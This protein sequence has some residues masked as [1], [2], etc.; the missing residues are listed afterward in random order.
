M[1]DLSTQVAQAANARRTYVRYQVLR[2]RGKRNIKRFPATHWRPLWSGRSP[3]CSVSAY[4]GV[5]GCEGLCVRIYGFGRARLHGKRFTYPH[6]PMP[7]SPSSVS[8]VYP[9]EEDSA[10]FG[11]NPIATVSAPQ[12]PM[13]VPKVCCSV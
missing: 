2:S 5:A 6:P 8:F 4:D 9:Q 7:H 3:A 10:N 12:P 13:T 1:R 11:P